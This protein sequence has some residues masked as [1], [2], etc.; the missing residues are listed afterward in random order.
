MIKRSFSAKLISSFVLFFISYV[1]D[2]TS[3]L[4]NLRKHTKRKTRN[5]SEIRSI[6]CPENYVQGE[7]HS[8]EKKREG[9]GG[10]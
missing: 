4:K 3:K 9:E 2:L 7:S 6:E 8:Y 5:E 1:Q 10:R